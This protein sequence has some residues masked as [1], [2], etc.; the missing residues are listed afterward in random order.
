MQRSNSAKVERDPITHSTARS[1]NYTPK[2]ADYEL[3]TEKDVAR[4]LRMSVY[5]LQRDRSRGAGIP[6]LILG[7]RSVRYSK[8]AVWAWIDASRS[9]LRR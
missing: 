1:S 9:E 4:I 7:R 2:G 5:K 3:L 6:Y 8:S